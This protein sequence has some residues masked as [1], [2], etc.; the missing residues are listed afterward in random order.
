MLT[1]VLHAAAVQAHACLLYS[2]VSIAANLKADTCIYCM[3]CL[4]LLGTQ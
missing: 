2:T 4:Y 1:E 3:M